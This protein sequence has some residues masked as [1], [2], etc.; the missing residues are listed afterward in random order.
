MSVERRDA[1]RGEVLGGRLGLH[2]PAAERGGGHERPVGV[3]FGLDGAPLDGERRL[4]AEPAARAVL[5]EGDDSPLG[6]PE[7]F[8]EPELS[9]SVSAAAIP[10]KPVTAAPMPS[11]TAKAPIRPT[12]LAH[13]RGRVA[14]V[15]SDGVACQL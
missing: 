8:V 1:A 12:Y 2:R 14:P 15:A 7:L 11:A 3:P 13:P 4:Q 9:D 6:E 5:E 10:G